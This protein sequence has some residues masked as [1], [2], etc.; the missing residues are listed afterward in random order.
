M[1]ILNK[2]SDGLLTVLLAVYRTIV[3][4]GPL[5]ESRIMS[6]C[7]PPSVVGDPKQLRETLTRWK[8]VGVLEERSGTL[9]LAPSI[10][11]I[12]VDDLDSLRFAL[13]QFVL[14]PEN[15]G[16]LT[17]E[18]DESRTGDWTRAAAWVLSQDLFAFPSNDA[19]AEALQNQQ[20]V[21]PRVF[22]NYTR[23]PGFVEW[24]CF[25]GI[26]WRTKAGPIFEP[27]FAVSRTL[28]TVFD[29]KEERTLAEFVERLSS[30]LPIFDG[31]TYANAVQAQVRN[32]WRV[33]RPDQI[34]PCLSAALERLEV[35]GT[36]RLESRSD[37]PQVSLLGRRGRERRQVSHVLR[38]GAPDA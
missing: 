6:L 36:V 2:A 7:A 31:G 8:Q 9:S 20:G 30:A 14:A 29:G 18:S 26:A 4:I 16:W 35:D 11:A 32:P 13:L 28:T 37:A 10:A 17:G 3:A 15:N 24:A 27:S 23:W 38:Q 19:G 1:S 33:G 12:P 21:E 25:L 34:S 5:E 22:Q